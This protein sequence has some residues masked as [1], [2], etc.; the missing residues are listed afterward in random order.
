M[1]IDKRLLAEAR[2]TQ[3]YL[4]LTAGLGFFVG[5]II[6]F[7]AH[8]LSRVVNQVFLLGETLADV[9]AWVSV[10]IVLAALRAGLTWGREAAA[11][12][13]AINIKTDLR[14]RLARQLLRLGPQYVGGE[15]SGELANTITEGVEALDAYFSQ[16]V[17]QLLLA[18]IIPLT[19]L[20]FILPL[21]LLTGFILLVTA[22]LIPLFMILI[23]DKA[24]TL[25]QR[26]WRVLSR[27][28]AFFL[29]VLQGLST[30][31]IFGHSKTQ[32]ATIAQ[33]SE[34]HRQTTMGVLRVAFLSALALELLATL[35]VAVVAVEIGIRVM[36]DRMAFQEAFFILILA[37][38]FYI[39]LRMLGTR[40]HAG[41]AGSVAA[42]RIFAILEQEPSQTPPTM[43]PTLTAQR[44]EQLLSPLRLQQVHVTYQDGAR[45][46]LND[47]SFTITPGEYI[48]LVGP[49]GA[50]KS[51]IMQ[52]L[53]RFV[54]PNQGRIVFG[55]QPLAQIDPTAWRR[56]IAWVPQRPYLF[57][58]S[59]AENILLGNPQASFQDI[60]R[61]AKQA[62][63]HEFIRTLLH[64][65][66]TIIGE[67]GARLSGGQIQRLALARAFL[68]D[69]PL[70]L[71]DEA[72]ANLDPET[73]DQIQQSITRLISQRTALV[74]AHR[75]NTVRNA[76]RILVMQ[77]GRIVETGS[78]EELVHDATSSGVYRSLVTAFGSIT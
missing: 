71:L 9:K 74:I 51:T 69:A 45:T 26:Q 22:P 31:K 72:T 32:I 63:A 70:V 5:L 1:R 41:M 27:L 53:L 14:E 61:A 13:M 2:T 75:L 21:D 19:V 66:D 12:N 68:K 47:V 55:D 36:V 4:L 30:L 60:Q 42:Q 38:A 52:L 7:Q 76:D 16:Y 10:L 20:A 33:I 77:G 35:S 17:P 65:Y 67:R 58:T 15:Q 11:Q 50:G 28:S 44:P 23:G 73:G 46:A 34:E 49:S 18:V 43:P 62:S 64:G 3:L 37:P 48:A 54:E 29:D 59:V 57:N 56:C 40:F 39:P 8:V 25:T 78:H 24:D 6:V